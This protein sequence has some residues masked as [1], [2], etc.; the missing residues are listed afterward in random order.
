[1]AQKNT[2]LTNKSTG[3]TFTAAD[4]N[5]LKNIIDSNASDSETRMTGIELGDY[6]GSSAYEIWLEEGHSGTKQEFLNSL[7][8]DTGAEDLCQ[9]YLI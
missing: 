2:N 4:F 1:M 5:E 7:K 6:N 8:G 3:D 9:T